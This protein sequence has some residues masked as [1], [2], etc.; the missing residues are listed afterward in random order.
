MNE[1]NPYRH[2]GGRTCSGMA[3]MLTLLG[4]LLALIGRKAAKR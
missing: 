1:D 4:T 2:P 3:A